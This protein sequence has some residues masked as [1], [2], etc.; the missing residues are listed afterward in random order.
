MRWDEKRLFNTLFVLSFMVIAARLL[1]M[2]STAFLRIILLS[3]S[4]ENYELYRNL[5][6]IITSVIK[7]WAIASGYWIGKKTDLSHQ[8]RGLLTRMGYSWVLAFIVSGIGWYLTEGIPQAMF[9]AA[10]MQ[11]ITGYK[12]LAPVFSGL[13]L[14][15]L[16]EDRFTISPVLSKDILNIV[17]VY[18]GV[19]LVST[20]VGS[21][22]TYMR[23]QT[24]Y[25][26]KYI[27]VYMMVLSYVL[28]PVS[29]WFLWKMYRSG[30]E[31]ELKSKYGSILYTLGVTQLVI[32]VIGLLSNML[33]TGQVNALD[34]VPELIWDIVGVSTSVFETGFALLCLGY[35]HSRYRFVEKLERIKETEK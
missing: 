2:G 23:I 9:Q 7:V 10:C 27:G 24:G 4:Q 21:Y 34:F 18:R 32:R 8:Y 20:L 29:Y 5:L 19:A 22:L 25:T 11:S 28:I 14:G 35:I 30:I 13:V 33:A 15:W 31:I 26:S 1:L 12:F 3:Y 6:R 17:L 16:I